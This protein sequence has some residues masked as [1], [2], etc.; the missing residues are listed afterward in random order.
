MCLP[1]K[2]GSRYRVKSG[3][4]NGISL[5]TVVYHMLT[6]YLP[7]SVNIRLYAEHQNTEGPRWSSGD[8]CKPGPHL[9]DEQNKVANVTH[10]EDEQTSHKVKQKTEPSPKQQ[11]F[12]HDG[13][14]RHTG[15]L[16]L[17]WALP[18]WRKRAIGDRSGD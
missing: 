16:S 3:A 1:D 13:L 5:G 11:T 2:D 4:G 17:W 9:K 15:Y 18:A 10:K 7:A 12:I 14:D 6:E 8:I